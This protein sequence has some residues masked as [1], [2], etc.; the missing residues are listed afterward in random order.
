M[1]LARSIIITIILSGLTAALGAWGATQ[2]FVQSQKR[3]TPLH[4][5]IHEQLKLTP[6]Q[7]RRIDGL[8]KDF[9]ARR[10]ALESEMR[11]ANVELAQAIQATHSYTPQVQAAIERFHAAMGEL[12]MASIQHV[13]AIRA[14]LT[15]EQA[16]RFDETV[17][18]SL[19]EQPV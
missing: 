3:A 9:A 18:K 2:Y 19:T 15:P 14:V 1:S 4:Q 8:E 10:K 13:I 5:V 12:Q 6:D 11:A 17:V 16:V 7:V